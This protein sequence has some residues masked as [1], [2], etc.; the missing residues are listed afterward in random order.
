VSFVYASHWLSARVRAEGRGT[1][2]ALDSNLNVNSYG[3]TVPE[4]TRLDRFRPAAGR[5]L[6]LGAGTDPTA[7]RRLLEIQGALAR[8][9]AVGPYP[10]LLLARPPV[11]PALD[12]HGWRMIASVAA[13]ETS[14]ALDGDSRTRWSAMGP[15]GRGAHLTVDVGEARPVAG[16]R[17]M[18]GPPDAGPSAFVLESSL[19]GSAWTPVGPSEWAGPLYWTGYELIRDGRRE[20]TAAFP[21]RTLRY[22]RVRPA[23]V[24]RT[25]EIAELDL[26]E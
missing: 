16:I 14:R 3:R 22:L 21:R 9:T 23:A 8:E 10:L 1:I 11:R 25:W 13:S 20:W 17:M 18:P 2:G 5:A 7:A 12:R 19:D 6:L 26:L 4:P 15:V 24:A